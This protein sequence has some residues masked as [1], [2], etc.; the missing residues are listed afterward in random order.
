MK[1]LFV[2]PYFPPRGGG[3]GKYVHAISSGLK[4]K[5]GWEVLI[6]TPNHKEKKYQEEILDDIKFYKLA[7]WFKISSTPVNP[8]WYFQIKKIIKKEKPDIV[9]AH[10]PVPFISDV[11]AR[12]CGDIPFVLTYQAASLYKYK[13][14]IFNTLVFLYKVFIERNTTKK[15]RTII[16][17]SDFVKMKFPISLKNKIIVINNSISEKD[18]LYKKT[19]VKNNMIIFIA[20]LNKPHSWKGLDKIIEAVK[21]YIQNFGE[22]IELVVVGDGDYRGHYEKLAEKLK[23][24]RYVKFVGTKLGKD[25]YSFL[26]KAKILV[27]YPITS[28]DGFPTVILDAWANLVPVIASNIGP[29]PYVIEDKKNGYLVEPG[30]PK[31]LAEG[32][33]DLM[34]NENL[35]N[36]LIRNGLYKVKDFTWEKSLE[37]THKLFMDLCNNETDA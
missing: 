29:L 34:H 6:V 3:M 16:A 20:S 18:I 19:S 37:I 15:T 7:S 32:I 13:T 5:Y 23:V 17:G 1:I 26:R 31:E 9:N 4:E 24:E 10:T 27:V 14:P 11:A 33:N 35:R 21:Y 2:T 28:N 30:S 8:M 25:Y 36:E 12:V 22:S